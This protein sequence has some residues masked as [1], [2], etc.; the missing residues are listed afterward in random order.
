M[1]RRITN[2]FVSDGRWIIVI[3]VLFPFVLI[4]LVDGITVTK[5]IE[6]NT[7]AMR[8]NTYWYNIRL[9][10]EDIAAGIAD[11]DLLPCWEAASTKKLY[12]R[13][14][15]SEYG[16]LLSISKSLNN[17]VNE[18][19]L[20]KTDRQEVVSQVV[21]LYRQDYTG[22]VLVRENPNAILFIIDDSGKQYELYVKNK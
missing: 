19:D 18:F 22:V 15:S 6:L 7:L 11:I 16:S 5:E 17:A 14:V 3:I 8:T 12:T 20:S 4:C 1:L 10:S 21:D 13:W 2:W 9:K